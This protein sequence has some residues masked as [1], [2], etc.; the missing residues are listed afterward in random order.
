MADGE[1]GTRGT[2]IMRAELDMVTSTSMDRHEAQWRAGANRQV[3]PDVQSHQVAASRAAPAAQTESAVS[4]EARKAKRAAAKKEARK[5]KLD[6]LASR[7]AHVAEGVSAAVAATADEL[8]AHSSAAV[9]PDANGTADVLC[10]IP[11]AEQPTDSPPVSVA[12]DVARN[13]SSDL[14]YECFEL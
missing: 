9:E 6:A 2:S 3:P 7:Q 14:E 8:T 11:L 10:E 5:R 13:F 1:C 4:V 12:N